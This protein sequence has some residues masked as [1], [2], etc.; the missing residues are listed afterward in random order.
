MPDE[1]WQGA[2]HLSR[3]APL[4]PPYPPDVQASFEAVMKDHEPLVLFRAVAA[5]ERVWRKFRVG[6]LVD[7]GPLILRQGE[8]VIGRTTARAAGEAVVLLD[9]P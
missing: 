3:V 1:K 2:T 9:D 6:S 8:I 5:G 7:R 4:E